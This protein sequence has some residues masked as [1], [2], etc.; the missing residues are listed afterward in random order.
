LPV[1]V[2]QSLLEKP[3]E[4][5]RQRSSVREVEEEKVEAQQED[6]YV[7]RE[8]IAFLAFA[9]HNREVEDMEHRAIAA[10]CIRAVP[11]VAYHGSMGVLLWDFSMGVQYRVLQDPLSKQIGSYACWIA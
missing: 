4:T 8:R 1:I 11:N 3:K 6:G 9:Q 7:A 10:G 2:M 5:Q